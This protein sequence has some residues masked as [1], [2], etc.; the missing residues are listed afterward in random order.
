MTQTRRGFIRT[1]GIFVLSAPVVF[2]LLPIDYP[3]VTRTIE[4]THGGLTLFVDPGPEPFA[5]AT[6]EHCMDRCVPRVFHGDITINIEE[7]SP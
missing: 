6:I 3:I 4:E 5:S 2:P 1:M 7:P